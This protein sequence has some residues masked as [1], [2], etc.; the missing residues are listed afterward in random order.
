MS[1]HK[2]PTLWKDPK[3]KKHLHSYFNKE[4]QAYTTKTLRAV[5]KLQDIETPQEVTIQAIMQAEK[6]G[7]VIAYTDEFIKKS[8]KR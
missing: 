7:L 6:K 1:D 3:F 8:N 5:M 2:Y 4:V